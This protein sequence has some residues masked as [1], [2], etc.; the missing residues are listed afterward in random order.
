M[1]WKWSIQRM[2]IQDKTSKWAAKARQSTV[3]IVLDLPHFWFGHR[4]YTFLP[5]FSIFAWQSNI[6]QYL[7]YTYLSVNDLNCKECRFLQKNFV[8]DKFFFEVSLKC[9]CLCLLF[10]P[11]LGWALYFHFPYP[12]DAIQTTLLHSF[13][14]M[15]FKW[16]QNYHKKQL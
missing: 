1:K 8:R 4:S 9:L 2:S 13:R 16:W 12:N 10:W 11:D 5:I 15:N 6:G 7:R 3:T 14:Q